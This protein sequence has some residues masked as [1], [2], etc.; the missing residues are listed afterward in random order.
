MRSLPYF[1]RRADFASPAFAGAE[2]DGIARNMV[3]SSDQL[4]ALLSGLAYL[5]AL[6]FTVTG[7]LKLKEH[8]SNP[9]QTPLRSS[10]IRFLV[11]GALLALPIV[12]QAMMV[13]FNAGVNPDFDGGTIR[14]YN[15]SPP[16][17]AASRPSYR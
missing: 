10:L 4:P 7:V 9:Q 15:S 3:Q 6:L 2:I 12:Y 13:T 14:P 11:G 8:V 17:L 16:C 5:L 1:C